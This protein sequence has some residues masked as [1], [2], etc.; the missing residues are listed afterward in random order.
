MADRRSRPTLSVCTRCRGID[1]GDSDEARAGYRLAQAIYDRF[2]ASAAARAGVRLR[3]VRCMSQCKRACA[4]ALSDDAKFTL[5]FGDLDPERDSDAVLELARL[6]A[7]AADGLVARGERPVALRAGILGRIPPLGVDS[8]LIDA[9]FAQPEPARRRSA[10]AV[11]PVRAAR[12]Q[13]RSA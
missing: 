13:R 12:T 10:P 11:S 5:L 8:A 9:A 3:G 4:I 6:Y 7:D 1:A 2:P